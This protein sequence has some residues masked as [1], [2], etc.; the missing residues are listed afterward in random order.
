MKYV[1]VSIRADNSRVKTNRNK[2]FFCIPIHGLKSKK[3]YVVYNS[4]LKKFNTIILWK[5]QF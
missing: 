5:I 1:G 3:K 2:L 4:L